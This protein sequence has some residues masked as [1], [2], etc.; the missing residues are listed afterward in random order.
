[1][2]HR[3]LKE[4]ALFAVLH[5][6]GNCMLEWL[7]HAGI[8]SFL[9]S[10]GHEAYRACST[11]RDRTSEI[12]QNS[13]FLFYLLTTFLL[14]VFVTLMHALT[15]YPDPFGNFCQISGMCTDY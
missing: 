13:E 14:L 15:Y 3:R 6:A 9:C 4:A 12:K 7:R 5:P 11:L 8:P 1:M 10:A 2:P